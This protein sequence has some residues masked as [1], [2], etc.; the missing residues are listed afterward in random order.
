MRRGQLLYD[1]F[2]VQLDYYKRKAVVGALCSNAPRNLN[3]IGARVVA[4]P[5]DVARCDTLIEAMTGLDR[6]KKSA[7]I[8]HPK[9]FGPRKAHTRIIHVG[10][11]TVT[12]GWTDWKISAPEVGD[13]LISNSGPEGRREWKGFAY[14]KNE[15]TTCTWCRPQAATGLPDPTV[16]CHGFWEMEFQ[17]SSSGRV[18]I[19]RKKKTD[20]TCS[21]SGTKNVDVRNFFALY[22]RK[23]KEHNIAA[24]ARVLSGLDSVLVT[25]LSSST[26]CGITMMDVV[27]ARA[28]I[29]TH[30]DDCGVCMPACKYTGGYILSVCQQCMSKL[31]PSDTVRLD[32]HLEEMSLVRNFGYTG[33]LSMRRC[34]IRVSGVSSG[35]TYSYPLSMYLRF[36]DAAFG[37]DDVMCGLVA[38]GVEHV[39]ACAPAIVVEDAHVRVTFNVGSGSSQVQQ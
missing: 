35:S 24:C 10:G 9:K 16:L 31:S 3:I 12:E 37:S 18:C 14:K 33:L 29:D 26:V 22:T 4:R 20:R 13:R 6:W 15:L 1:P 32:Q 11:K 23:V 5:D 30:P 21:L 25:R 27:C 8:T 19:S 2:S 7:D 36:I 28:V 17:F 39:M 38:R 34:R